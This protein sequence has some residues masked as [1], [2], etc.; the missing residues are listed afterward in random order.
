MY[1][2]RGSSAIDA[3]RGEQA[4]AEPGPRALPE[5]AAHFGLGRRHREQQAG[6]VL[7][8]SHAGVRRLRHG[9]RIGCVAG[10]RHAELPCL[11]HDGEES[12]ARQRVVDL[13]EVV[14]VGARALHRL[15]AFIR[16]RDG[17]G[18]WPVWFRP[19][20]DVARD[21]EPRAHEPAGL[22][23]LAPLQ[24]VRLAPHHA[25]AGDAVRSE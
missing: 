11:V 14:A 4:L 15:P 5:L 16:R 22:D 23:L 1:F 2:S 10:H 17:D 21:R 18:S 13:D 20:D 25:H 12:L 7:D 6:Q 9:Q 8:A 19:V 24:M 3:S